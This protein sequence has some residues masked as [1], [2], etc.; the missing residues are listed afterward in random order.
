[1]TLWVPE[2]LAVFELFRPHP[3][4]D[5]GA[6]TAGVT[7]IWMG[8]D[9]PAPAGLGTAQGRLGVPEMAGVLVRCTR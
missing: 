6:F 8:D 2:R 7:H 3:A 5:G 9:L 4:G 1:M